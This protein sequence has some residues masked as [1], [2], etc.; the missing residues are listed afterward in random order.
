MKTVKFTTIDTF[1]DI[2][3]DERFTQLCPDYKTIHPYYLV[4]DHK[5]EQYFHNEEG[6]AIYIRSTDVE[7][8]YL[9]GT[10]F[11]KKEDWEQKVKEL[12]F[13]DKMDKIINDE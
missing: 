4:N 3:V 2:C 1:F 8:Y 10:F 12:K 9:H 7:N 13:N 6:P 5:I 11:E